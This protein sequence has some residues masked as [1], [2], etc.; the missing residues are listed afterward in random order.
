MLN[1]FVYGTLKVGGRFAE[2]FD[3]FRVSVKNGTLKNV[4]LF[5]LGSFPAIID[6]TNKVFGEIHQYEQEET[7]LK[8]FDTI[9]GYNRNKES[10][11]FYIR[12]EVTVETDDG[13]EVRAIAYFMNGRVPQ[14]A[15][16]VTSGTWTAS[17]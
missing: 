16:Q 17:E 9:E 13:K 4:D 3:K 6:G 12:K 11:S 15:R 10:E 1:F 8:I 2:R 5:D 14:S 7:V